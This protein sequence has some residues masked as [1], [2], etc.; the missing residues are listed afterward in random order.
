M[1]S[2]RQPCNYPLNRVLEWD[3]I[4]RGKGIYQQRRRPCGS[5]SPYNGL[6][7]EVP[8]ACTIAEEPVTA[9][10]PRLTAKGRPILASIWTPGRSEITDPT[11]RLIGGIAPGAWRAIRAAAS[12]TSEMPVLWSSSL[13][14]ASPPLRWKRQAT[15]Y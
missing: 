4:A 2:I 14:R 5:T 9:T 12:G 3:T 1:L 8:L 7:A 11:A 15:W 6:P 13:R 10:E